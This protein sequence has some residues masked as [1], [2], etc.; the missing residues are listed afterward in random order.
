MGKPAAGSLRVQR[1][2]EPFERRGGR[3][4]LEEASVVVAAV[5]VR[6]GEQLACTSGVVRRLNSKP[7]SLPGDQAGRG[8]VRVAGRQLQCAAGLLCGG[9]ECSGAVRLDRKSTRLNSSH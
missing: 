2:A 5:Q 6:L 1:G 7:Q 4:Q 3:A 8:L 9:A